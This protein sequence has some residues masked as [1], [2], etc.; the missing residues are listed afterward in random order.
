MKL[1]LISDNIDTQMGLR[2]AGIEGV[3]INSKKE[4]QEVLKQVLL[5]EEIGILL[6]TSI[7]Y[8]YGRDELDDMKL[9]LSRP[10]IVEISDRHQSLDVS[11]MIEN[12][13]KKI[14][15]GIS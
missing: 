12:T 15:G 14:T 8:D 13:L 2:L 7:A 10:L 11:D 3:V 9:N 6:L 1:Y 4:Y 5:D